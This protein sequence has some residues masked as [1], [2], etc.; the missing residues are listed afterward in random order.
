MYVASY[1]A[2]HLVRVGGAMMIIQHKDRADDR[3]GAHQHDAGKI[4]AYIHR[5]TDRQATTWT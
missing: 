3:Q 2:R 1:P 5:Q 4:A